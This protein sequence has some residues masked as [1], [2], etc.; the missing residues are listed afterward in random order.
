MAPRSSASVIQG[1]VSHG[2]GVGMTVKGEGG[3]SFSWTCCR[4]FYC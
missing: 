4:T 2:R 3:G 1:L